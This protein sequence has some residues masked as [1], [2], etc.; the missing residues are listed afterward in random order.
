MYVGGDMRVCYL[1]AVCLGTFVEGDKDGGEDGGG[2]GDE[3][4]DGDGDEDGGGVDHE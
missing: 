1:Y 2:H 3:N 4:G